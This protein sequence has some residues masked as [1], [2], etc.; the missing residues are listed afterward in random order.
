M[1]LQFYIKLSSTRLDIYYW[2]LYTY[3]FCN[4][5]TIDHDFSNKSYR[6]P[7]AESLE[8]WQKPINTLKRHR[9]VTKTNLS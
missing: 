7:T 5:M 8:S 4:K 9:V 2:R 1:K 6:S 3:F